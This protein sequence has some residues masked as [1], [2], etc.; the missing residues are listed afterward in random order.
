MGVKTLKGSPKAMKGDLCEKHLLGQGLIHYNCMCWQ[1]LYMHSATAHSDLEACEKAVLFMV[2]NFR[3]IWYVS[4]WLRSHLCVSMLCWTDPLEENN[5]MLQPHLLAQTISD[6]FTVCKYRYPICMYTV[7]IYMVSKYLHS[8]NQ[9]F[10]Q[11]LVTYIYGL[12][13]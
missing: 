7:Y 11:S 3:M 8:N 1:N 12:G 2:Q 5:C 9:Q 4:G 10:L 6:S 13:W